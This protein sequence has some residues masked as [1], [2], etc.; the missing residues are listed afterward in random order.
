MHVSHPRH[1]RPA[2]NAHI[3]AGCLQVLVPGV[4]LLAPRAVRHWQVRALIRRAPQQYTLQGWAIRRLSQRL[5][6]ENPMA[7]VGV[8]ILSPV[9]RSGLPLLLRTIRTGRWR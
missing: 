8:Y 3:V 2:W 7:H 6:P 1:W 5:V 9:F 4:Y